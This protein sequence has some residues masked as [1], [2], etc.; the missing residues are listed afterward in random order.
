MTHHGGAH[1]IPSDGRRNRLVRLVACAGA[2]VFAVAVATAAMH[3]QVG[4]FVGGGEGEA[5]GE[6]GGGRDGCNA[7]YSLAFVR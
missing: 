2:L 5:V 7:S 1:P 3:H 6:G 4:F